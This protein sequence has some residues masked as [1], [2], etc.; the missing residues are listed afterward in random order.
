MNIKQTLQTI[1]ILIEFNYKF[2][3]FHLFY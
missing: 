2:I 3:Q 1:N